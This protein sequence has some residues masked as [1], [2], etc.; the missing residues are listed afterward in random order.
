M[1]KRNDIQSI[2]VIGSGPIIIGQA[3]EFDYAG[4]QACLALKEEGYRVILVNSNPATIMTDKE[5]ADKV[6]IEPLTHDF[7]ARIIRKEQPDALLPT[8][9]GQTG[10]NMAIELHNSGVLASNNVKLLG[11]ELDSIERAEDR[12]RFRTLMNELNVPVPESDI[13]NTLEQAF[14]FKEEVGYPLIVRPAFT[15]GGTGGG[16]C[17]NDDELKEVVTNGLKYSPATQCLIEKSIA[18][19]KEIEYEV[20]RDKNDNAIVVCNMENIDPVG[21]HTGD[22]VVVAPSQT[23]SDV[24]YQMLRDVSLK[25][26]RALGIEGGCNVQL[27]LD[28]HSMNYYIIE[29]NPRVSRSSALASKATGYPIAKLAAKIAVG[30]T[31]DEMKNPV[32]GTS[33]AAFEPSLDYIVSK[34][35]R[36]PFDK[37]EKGERELG[38]QMKATG[39]VMSIGRT[40]EESLLKA[41]R[42]LEYGV[43]H[44]GL[45]NGESFD[46]SYI[47]ERIKAQDDER[48]FFIGEAI[49]RGTTLE[50]IHEMTKIDY[51][52]LNKFK[53]IIDMEHALKANKGDIDY[54]KFA[55]RFGFSDRTI[56]H[57]FEMTEEEVFKLRQQHQ[58][59]PVYKMVDT[60]AAEFESTTP[61]FY[62]TYEEENESIVT[63]KEKIIVLG[64]GPI[65][66]G[67][68]VE[69]DYA[70]VHAVWA[71]QNAGYEAIIVNNNPETV[72]TDFSISDKLYF[73]PLTEEDVMNIIQLE[74]PKG[75]VVQ[76]G[77]Q[78]AI[79]LADKLAKHGVQILGTTLEDLNRAEDRKEFEALLNRIQVP[80][81]K[82]KTATSA[83]EALDNAREIGYPV[84]VRPSYVLGGRAMEIVYSDAELENYMNEAVKA[85]P[86]HPV[87]VDRYLT[88][89]EIEVDAICDGETVMIPGIMEHIERAGVHSGD[90]IAVYPPQ[91]LSQ[92]DIETLEAYTIKL[93]K[94][95][96]VIGLINIQ[97]V[98]AHDGVYVLEVN[99]RSSRTVPF[100]SKITEIQMAQLAMRAIMGEKLQDLGYMQGVQPYKEGVFVKAPVFS[101]NKLKNVDITL[102]PEMKSTG[103]V[104]GRD[105]TLEKA[106]YKGLTASGMEVKDYGTALITVSD[107]DKQEMVKIAQRLNQIGYKIIATAG[108]AKVLAE[109]D[110]K[111]ET[112][113]KIGGEDD[114]LHKIQEGDVQIVINT[115]TKGKTIERDGFQIRRTSVENGIPCLTSLD[116]AN[117]LTNVIE[118]MSFSMRNM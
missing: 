60:C 30:L 111:V 70:T 57:R 117:A 4:T 85:S 87:L 40:Y 73:E 58:I 114:L 34:I 11:T 49:R 105:L 3:A 77:G 64:S 98:L 66:I 56:A 31:L 59:Q 109:H 75:V 79:N 94:G 103:E 89:K 96:N 107:K 52:F 16:I 33:Y 47:K 43:H 2:L 61:Y 14:Q 92:E 62:G 115:M 101:F 86:E 10:L 46:L 38:T 13:V 22:S 80:Q 69:F 29:V 53:N 18:G 8:L 32:T 84:V 24:E 6:Y 17:Y 88:G 51:F 68:G 26:I 50:E 41:I 81:P 118:S 23:L 78:T 9:G 67:Q 20:M 1:P 74:Q 72:S 45:P 71:I 12:E 93:A 97:F 55:K 25:V 112:V 5:I 99:P 110:I 83:K 35:P 91:T 100:L 65:R 108:T 15:M 7:I 37:F 95:L 36:F 54:L 48:L 21:I 42:S 63:D 90:S 44:L 28:P 116:T 104:M 113:G 106:L 102:G 39:E 76:F 27:A 19:Y 82:G